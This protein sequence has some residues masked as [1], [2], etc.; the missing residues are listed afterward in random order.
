MFLNEISMKCQTQMFYISCIS[1]SEPRHLGYD[2]PLSK[3]GL[4]PASCS[5]FHSIIARAFVFLWLLIPRASSAVVLGD[6]NIQGGLP[7]PNIT[8]LQH[9]LNFSS[10]ANSPNYHCTNSRDWIGRSKGYEITDC[11]NARLKFWQNMVATHHEEERVEYLGYYAEPTT[12]LEK[13]QTPLRFTSGKWAL[14]PD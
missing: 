2:Q 12:H 7:S 11:F 1:R 4:H 6:I 3:M 14:T 10:S 9:T 8:Q 13:V 5:P